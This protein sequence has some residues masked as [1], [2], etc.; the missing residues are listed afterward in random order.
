MPEGATRE[1]EGSRRETI[2]S[3]LETEKDQGLRQKAEGGDVKAEG[4]RFTWLNF[5]THLPSRRFKEKLSGCRV[6]NDCS[7]TMLNQL[8]PHLVARQNRFLPVS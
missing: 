8:T 2:V 3:M 4:L 6:A 1:R 7:S 5:L